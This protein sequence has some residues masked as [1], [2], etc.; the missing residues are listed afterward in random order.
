M[1]TGPTTTISSHP[2]PPIR[3]E[4]NPNHAG[5]CSIYTD[6]AWNPVTG[7][8]RLGWV[9]DELAS[10]SQHLCDLY[11][12]IVPLLAESLAVL[13]AITF[14]H[15]R[16]IDSIQ[17]HSD[18]QTLINTINRRDMNLEIFDILQDIYLFASLFKS[19]TFIFIPRAAN[20]LADS[21]AKQTLWALNSI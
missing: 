13:A 6:A 2:K 18:S 21:I 8:A 19:I 1:E 9:L 3:S 16:G 5:L 10:P 4:P 17:L 20:V 15:S 11:L 12:C 7:H 14:A